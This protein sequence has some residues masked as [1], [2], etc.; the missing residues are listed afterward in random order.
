MAAFHS[1]PFNKFPH[2]GISGDLYYASDLS[3]LYLC[4]QGY[5]FR[6]DGILGGGISLAQP[7]LDLSA[8]SD[9]NLSG[10]QNGD[11]LTYNAQTGKWVNEQPQ[12]GIT[13][14]NARGIAI[15]TSIALS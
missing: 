6:L 4:A 5:M 7:P 14:D 15:A 2:N 8:F 1:M 12:A 3:D 10:L 9:V 11:V 13:A